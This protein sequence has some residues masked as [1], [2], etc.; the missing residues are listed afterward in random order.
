MSYLLILILCILPF[1]KVVRCAFFNLPYVAFYSVR[2]MILYLKERKWKY[3][4]EYGVDMFIGMFGHGKTLSMVHKA[5][6]LYRLYGDSI[7]FISNIELKGIPYTPLVNFNQL[8]DLGE[9]PEEGK[10][11]TVV[12]I[13]EISSVLSHRNYASF[14]LELIGLLCQQRKRHVYIM[15]TAQRFFMVDK[16]WR[17]ITTNVY[18]CEKLWRFQHVS[19][20]DAWDYENS[21]NTHLIRKLGHTWW[22]VRDIDFA[23]YDT[24]QMIDKN[25]VSD[26]ISNEESIVR[27]GLDSSVNE[28]AIKKPS[29]KF[30]KQFRKKG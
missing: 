28:L 22:F 30:R 26:F 29:R 19:C 9:E 4:T 12:L 13:D 18:D 24:S 23:S 1:F 5:R 6:S 15:C 20:Y 16:I 11:G 21:M 3:F 8:V 2:D 7:N 17:S 25:M 27:K 10:Q 14:P